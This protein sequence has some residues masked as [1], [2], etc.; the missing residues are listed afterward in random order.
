MLVAREQVKKYA[1]FSYDNSVSLQTDDAGNVGAAVLAHLVCV[2]GLQ[3]N[4]VR[5][6]WKVQSDCSVAHSQKFLSIDKEKE[7]I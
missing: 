6:N 1:G 7:I 5:R 4:D 2:V 3:T